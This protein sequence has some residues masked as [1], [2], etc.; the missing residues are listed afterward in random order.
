MCSCH[1]ISFQGSVLEI[2]QLLLQPKSSQQAFKRLSAGLT[3]YALL[4]SG[5]KSDVP[6]TVRRRS[7]SFQASSLE[8]RWWHSRCG[9]EEFRCVCPRKRT[10]LF[11]CPGKGPHV[12]ED[13]VFGSTNGTARRNGE[14]MVTILIVVDFRFA[15]SL[16]LL[17]I[18]NV[19]KRLR[20]TDIMRL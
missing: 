20:P 11:F 13:D 10:W 8:R 9:E 16:L 14:D 1:Q 19:G 5:P 3:Y 12:L 17:K 2:G 7:H 4:P 18:W 6:S 15:H